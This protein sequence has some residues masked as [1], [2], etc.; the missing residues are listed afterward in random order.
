VQVRKLMEGWEVT[1]WAPTRGSLPLRI[2]LN[3]CTSLGSSWLSDSP[4]VYN[5]VQKFFSKLQ[6]LIKA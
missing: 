3:S 4:P 6:A 5:S 1:G 2:N